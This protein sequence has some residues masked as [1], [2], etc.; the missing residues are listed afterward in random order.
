MIFTKLKKKLKNKSLQFRD[1]K[2]FFSKKLCIIFVN[3]LWVLTPN[4]LLS[5]YNEIE[6]NVLVKD[7]LRYFEKGKLIN[8]YS[9]RYSIGKGLERSDEYYEFSYLGK[10]YNL[11]FGYKIFDKNFKYIESSECITIDFD[12]NN[13]NIN[14][15]DRDKKFWY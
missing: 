9:N 5:G 13:K 14:D 3:I 2:F 1:F 8:N 15:R 12:K 11:F 4:L 6:E 10:Y 7:C